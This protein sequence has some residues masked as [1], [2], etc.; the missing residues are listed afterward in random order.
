MIRPYVYGTLNTGTQ[1]GEPL[2]GHRKEVR[3]VRFSP[4]GTLLASASLDE[5]IQIYPIQIHNWF[6]QEIKP[7]QVALLKHAQQVKTL[8][9]TARFRESA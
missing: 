4:G 3:S 8:D 7:E 2:T 9:F 1:I 5:G 6:A